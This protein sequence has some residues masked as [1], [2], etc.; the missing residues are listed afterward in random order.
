M[1]RPGRTPDATASFVK[2]STAHADWDGQS[3]TP[4]SS[5]DGQSDTGDFA[6][7]L[8]YCPGPA[9]SKFM[10][11][12]LNAGATTGQCDRG[13]PA[14][15]HTGVVNVGLADG[16]VRFVTSGVSTPTWWNALTPAGGEFL[17]SDG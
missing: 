5:P 16:S 7:K 8:A 17:G 3:R 10:T 15:M 6:D 1:R 4:S 11:W 14:S 2:R 13:V 12:P 9:N